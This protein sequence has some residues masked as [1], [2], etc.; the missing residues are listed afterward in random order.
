MRGRVLGEEPRPCDE[1]GALVIEALVAI[2][3]L[4]VIA[5]S[6]Q[7][8]HSTA[9]DARLRSVDRVVALWEARSS[10]E[11]L[12]AA[13]IPITSTGQEAW[14]A[15]LGPSSLMF[16]MGVVA[17]DVPSDPSAPSGRCLGP[18]Q[19]RTGASVHAVSTR[20]L[21]GPA[22]ASMRAVLTPG[23]RGSD[24]VD[25][26]PRSDAR[27]VVRL[28]G[29][30]GAAGSE[31]SVGAGMEVLVLPTS[32]S[33][34]G[35]Q[36]P[37]VAV[38]AD[39]DGCAI[40]DELLVGNHHVR[41]LLEDG[42]DRLHRPLDL[43]EEHVATLHRTELVVRADR[44]ATLT[45]TIVATGGARLPDAPAPGAD[46][47]SWTVAGDGVSQPALSGELRRLHPGQVAIVVGV[48]RSPL[49]HATWV[50]H[51]L[52]VGLEQEIA[53]SLPSVELPPITVPPGGAHIV[54]Q[55]DADC[56]GAGGVRPELRWTEDNDTAVA[57]TREPHLALPNGRWQV[58][59]ESS[60]GVLLAGPITLEV[61]T[62]GE[63]G[64]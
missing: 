2:A 54:A 14:S 8:L 29:S 9:V 52:A 19:D 47:L 12:Q 42:L 44:A 15:A 16:D 4:G 30:D 58:R 25:S 53:V 39:L 5:G 37:P 60:A 13:R 11:L 27:L 26:T 32:A 35:G 50:V 34:A 59:I 20:D 7:V 38:H 36:A 17:L 61:S 18:D 40:V 46:G 63:V 28:V 56:P 23:G 1:S 48:C 62:S 64:P 6:A 3:L 24:A 55:R 51:D 10:L 22:V 31:G 21:D 45:T 57:S 43:V 33:A 49:E 41:V